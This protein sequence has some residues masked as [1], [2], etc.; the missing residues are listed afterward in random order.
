MVA[1][2]TVHH[3]C[4]AVSACTVVQNHSRWLT[5][6]EQ[7]YCTCIQVDMVLYNVNDTVPY[8]AVS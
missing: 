4:N 6:V 5:G 1:H 3:Q 2:A 7:Q 8:C